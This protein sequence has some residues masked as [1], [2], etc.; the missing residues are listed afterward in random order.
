MIDAVAGA[1]PGYKGPSYSALRGK[2]LDEEL[3][4]IKEQLESIKSS[5]EF[6]G[7]T[8]LSDGGQIRG[9]EQS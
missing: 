6:I 7:C 8:I 9:I 2:D 5:W 3:Q 4:C 1:G